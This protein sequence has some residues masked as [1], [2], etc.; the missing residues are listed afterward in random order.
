MQVTSVSAVSSYI[1]PRARVI[2]TP[3]SKPNST[4]ANPSNQVYTT[5]VAGK[6]YSG[7]ITYSS[8]VYVITVPNL[9]GSTVSAGSLLAAE[10]ALTAR[11]DILV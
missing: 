9:P 3:A 6:R 2:A 1:G 8:G 7:D 4:A 11:I 5:T 10:N